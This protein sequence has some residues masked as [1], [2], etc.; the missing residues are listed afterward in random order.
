M[1]DHTYEELKKKTV[2]E[3]REIAKDLKHEAI[4]GYSQLTRNTYCRRSVGRSGS[5]RT[6]TVWRQP[7]VDHV[8]S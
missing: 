8:G 2:A 7:N 4:K 6:S 1:A 5:T 3:L